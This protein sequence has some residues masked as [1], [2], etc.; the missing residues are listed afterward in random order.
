MVHLN[1]TDLFL[2][3]K[4]FGQNVWISKHLETN[5]IK[6]VGC[7]SKS[8]LSNLNSKLENKKLIEYLSDNY[9]QVSV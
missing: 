1:L 7:G 9:L 3:W 2:L 6:L 4:Y 5:K 8:G